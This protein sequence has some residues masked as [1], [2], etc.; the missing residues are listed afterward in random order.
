MKRKSFQL[1]VLTLALCVVGL[2]G[3]SPNVQAQYVMGADAALS[4]LTMGAN[5]TIQTAGYNLTIDGNTT[6][7]K[8][9][10]LITIEFTG[11]GS[12]LILSS[13]E[14]AVAITVTASGTI[15][16]ANNI[17]LSGGM[18]VS[19]NQTVTLSGANATSVFG[20][21][22]VGSNGTVVAS[23]TTGMAGTLT[24][25]GSTAALNI[26]SG[27]TFTVTASNAIVNSAATTVT[28]ASNGTL[29]AAGNIS[30]GANMT[31]SNTGNTTLTLNGTKLEAT[32]AATFTPG[33]DLTM[34]NLATLGGAGTLTL[35]GNKTL[36]TTTA[37]TLGGDVVISDQAKFYHNV[38][39]A[40][41]INGTHTL[42]VSSSV[43]DALK[44]QGA[45][46]VEV[47]GG[48]SVGTLV[49][50][51]ASTAAVNATT[52][53]MAV[54]NSALTVSQPATILDL[55]ISADATLNLASTLTV[56][57]AWNDEG[58]AMTIDG[59]GVGTLAGNTI[60]L[61]EG[62]SWT[63]Q[64]AYGATISADIALAAA[65]NT[66]WTLSNNLTY[67]G[68]NITV[69]A[70]N[71]IK[72][73]G[74]GTFFNTNP[75]VLAGVNSTLSFGSGAA[76]TATVSKVES[77]ND[78]AIIAVA[79]NATNAKIT[80]LS[81]NAT[82][83]GAT[84]SYAAVGAGNTTTMTFTNGITLA[85]QTGSTTGA[86]FKVTGGDAGT[87]Y[88][89][90]GGTISLGRNTKLDID[91]SFGTN[92]L[93]LNSNLTMSEQAEI[94]LANNVYYKGTTFSLDSSSPADTLS[95]TGGG[96]FYNTTA[97]PIDIS[98]NKAVLKF[99]TDGS[100]VKA[101]TASNAG[102]YIEMAATGTIDT[103]TAT[104]GY[105][106]DYSGTNE[107]LTVTTATTVPASG[108]VL[109]DGDSKGL[110]A[111]TGG[112]D[113]TAA[114]SMLKSTVNG[115]FTINIPIT[116]GATLYLQ[117][118][119]SVSSPITIADNATINVALKTGEAAAEVD[120]LGADINVGAYT[121]TFP[122]AGTFDNATSN[123]VLDNAASE[124]V[125]TGNTSISKVTITADD[126]TVTMNGGDGAINTL[127]TGTY[128]FN[129]NFNDDDSFELT[130]AIALGANQTVTVGGSGA[131]TLKGQNITVGNLGAVLSLDNTASNGLTVQN[132][133]ALGVASGS[134]S[135]PVIDVNG[136]VTMTGNLTHTANGIVDIE[137]GKTFSY[138]GTAFTTGDSLVFKG[139]GTFANSNAFT[140]SAA[141]ILAFKGGVTASRVATGAATSTIVVI[142]ASPT[143][144]TLDANTYGGKLKFD[145]ASASTSKTITFTN[146][147]DLSSGVT[148]EVIA[149]TGKGTIAGGR[150]DVT[151]AASVFKNSAVNVTVAADMK[152]GAA[153]LDVDG[154]PITVSGDITLDGNATID[155]DAAADSLVY[156]GTAI[157]IGANTLTI[158]GNGTVSNTGYPIT[159][160][161]A[162]SILALTNTG[163]IRAIASENSMAKINVGA[164]STVEN[165]D[166]S[167]NGVR[168]AYTA[169]GKT[170]TLGSDATLAAGDSL[171]FLDGAASG[172]LAGGTKDLYLTGAGAKLIVHESGTTLGLRTYMGNTTTAAELD[173]NQNTTFSGG[174]TFKGNV[175]IDVAANKTATFDGTTNAINAE[176]SASVL[177]ETGTGSVVFTGDLELKKD[178][179]FAG[180]TTN[181]YTFTG[182]TNIKNINTGTSTSPSTVTVKFDTCF[183]FSGIT[184]GTNQVG[185]ANIYSLI[186]L[187]SPNEK[188][189]FTFPRDAV[190]AAAQIGDDDT[191]TF[192]AAA[193]QAP[194]KITGLLEAA[195]GVATVKMDANMTVSGWLKASSGTLQIVD[196][197]SVIHHRIYLTGAAAGGYNVTGGELVLPDI[198]TTLTSGGV[199]F[200]A[201]V[202]G[203]TLRGTTAA[204]SVINTTDMTNKLT[205]GIVKWLVFTPAISGTSQDVDVD[206]FVIN[207]YVSKWVDTT[208]NGS[209]ASPYKTIEE[210]ITNSD[211]TSTIVVE[212][213]V[214][215]IAA[216]IEITKPVTLKG[217][218]GNAQ[219]YTTLSTGTV[220]AA[221]EAPVIRYTG[222]EAIA[223]MIHVNNT[224]DYPDATNDKVVIEGFRFDVT[225]M[226][227]VAI[228]F[229][230]TVDAVDVNYNTF[231]L[232]AGTKA[233]VVDTG[234]TLTTADFE[235][236]KVVASDLT[237]WFEIADGNAGFNGLDLN[238]NEVK[239]AQACITLSNGTLTD[240]DYQNNTI[241]NG[242]GLKLMKGADATG[243][244]NG[245]PSVDVSNNDFT[246]LVG[247]AVYVDAT[248]GVAD[249]TYTGSATKYIS[250]KVKVNNNN[251]MF[252]SGAET[253]A[254]T[255]LMTDVTAAD[256]YVDAENNWWGSFEG[257]G[258]AY[259]A[260]V[261][262][263]VDYS[264]FTLV[265]ALTGNDIVVSGVASG[266]MAYSGI[267]VVVY[268]GPSVSAVK[269]GTNFE[270]DFPD[271]PLTVEGN[272]PLANETQ[273]FTI[274]PKVM[275]EVTDA[276]ITVYNAN[277]PA[278]FAETNVFT[279]S[280]VT[281]AAPGYLDVVDFPSDDGGKVLMSFIP[282]ANHPGF[283]DLEG[284]MGDTCPIDYYQVYASETNV[285]TDAINWAVVAATAKASGQND[286]VRVIVDTHGQTSG[287]FWLGA[288][289]G[290]LPPGLSS[291]DM[292]GKVSEGFVEAVLIEEVEGEME[293]TVESDARAVSD[294]VGP[295]F[296]MSVR[297]TDKVGDFTGDETVGLDD[298]AFFATV[299]DNS[300][301]FDA[302]FDLDADGKVGLLDFA[303]FAG[304][305]GS[306]SSAKGI[307]AYSEGVND[308]TR[309]EMKTTMDNNYESMSI[310]VFARDA[311]ELGGYSFELVFDPK[312][313]EFVDA[314]DGGFLEDKEGTAPLFLKNT[315]DGKVTV[316]NVLTD[317]T[318]AVSG[319]GMVA[320]LT[321]RWIGSDNDRMEIDGINVI[322]PRGRMNTLEKT[323]VDNP[324][325]LPD[326]FELKQN[327]PNPF[328]P[329]TNISFA[330]PEASNVKIVI[331]NVLGQ[332]VRTLVDQ[333]FKAG[334]RTIRWDGRNDIGSKVAS[335][336][337]IYRVVSGKNVATKKMTLLK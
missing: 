291:S 238:Y 112:I 337:Y 126:A 252:V 234:D 213:G 167:A 121:V 278:N 317:M 250:D 308:A 66:T 83:T 183:T 157:G 229:E 330:L 44:V 127:S 88:N 297:N 280:P 245:I 47:G 329:E 224:A 102:A 3:F 191:L 301:E 6:A 60:T 34:A 237:T 61:N 23:S 290:P 152:I 21:V 274:T 184:G 165:L 155:V 32:A 48:G 98:A 25:A 163:I 71:V 147:W 311:K 187:Q 108:T 95:I 49:L 268:V 138:E 137:S 323:G 256:D 334:V 87:T 324:V 331:Y 115:G 272:T 193:G 305:F 156:S 39:A 218:K 68:A 12:E 316:A 235:Y 91:G 190:M 109:L 164:S 177:T 270:A 174:V 80:T 29:V 129:I 303:I 131:G 26:A 73:E 296:S 292:M 333:E 149:G 312:V 120:Y 144:T 154:G 293:N 269:I 180:G 161:N 199:G 59:A 257:P 36:T 162:S 259:G 306:T 97:N 22:S 30:L 266:Q 209:E 233:I 202:T 2:L 243:T 322:D 9:L 232:A 307:M 54:A 298:F 304:E 285:F 195:G 50:N 160:D 117:D 158:A 141:N 313:Y 128:D 122:G 140:V 284:Y 244:F 146:S 228:T 231:N 130:G 192:A 240:L 214:Y 336:M 132:N 124:I 105:T 135:P 247:Y 263:N 148:F 207:V 20:N 41:V 107:T 260:A 92:N 196:T 246:G 166:I 72:I 35:A 251:F 106:V 241:T 55:D 206:G 51:S 230:D 249:F 103:L 110:F 262:A 45:Q 208:G 185:G 99:A 28:F 63:A 239:N 253:Y 295:D 171:V 216:Q 119:M 258:Q 7:D 225:A 302:L 79:Q 18:T 40:F 5:T 104:T 14:T 75:I 282:S 33:E 321:F 189:T 320:R 15:S 64:N 318:K 42:T 114:G 142:D 188:M 289:K 276:K 182:I 220:G 151:G 172:T 194:T 198:D 74:T 255:N 203:G 309:F 19:D 27:K 273:V 67:G 86:T 201:A 283:S 1:F 159:L 43:A 300:G 85:S 205:G 134:Y 101:V 175:N 326:K 69:A 169:A 145:H 96:T 254:V 286:T 11:S 136:K 197:N 299:F 53:D 89:L 17:T 24:F 178:L 264:P 212:A 31:W 52:I 93:N 200:T 100:T 294:K 219:A 153:T 168:I 46:N 113:V 287:Y 227:P 13:D 118:T 222:T 327:Y 16:G 319:E 125:F 271:G 76:T 217:Y 325:P 186:N 328:N 111:G 179:Q 210:A 65:T 84:L 173:L 314:V 236:N 57:T 315:R 275:S 265:P 116:L 248:L 133:V 4:A 211:A 267:N 176:T 310:E 226:S 261:S 56:T 150:V 8:L 181:D 281:I 62:G 277:S 221:D 70:G 90:S 204:K 143:I 78:G 139:A 242:N 215:E 223:S 82:T 123:L 58:N 170:L 288:V 37:T 94:D 77:G 332:K 81:F 38:G 279:I 335:G 10:N